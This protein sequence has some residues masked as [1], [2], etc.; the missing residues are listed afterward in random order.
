MYGEVSV[1]HSAA[2]NAVQTEEKVEKSEK[3][4]DI[5]KEE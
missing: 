1:G 2:W 5:S 3:K 4:V